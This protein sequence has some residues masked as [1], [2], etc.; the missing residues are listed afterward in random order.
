MHAVEI[1]NAISEHPKYVVLTD[2]E[3]ETLQQAMKE[4]N[5]DMEGIVTRAIERYLATFPRKD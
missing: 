2:E 5:T 1:C 4:L 3:Y